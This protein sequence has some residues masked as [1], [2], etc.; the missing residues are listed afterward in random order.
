MHNISFS[1]IVLR[2][3]AFHTVLCQL[4]VLGKRFADAGLRDILIE[5]VVIAEGSAEAV[6]DGR[7]YNRAMRV[8]KVIIIYQLF[9]QKIC[10]NYSF[11]VH[12]WYYTLWLV[13]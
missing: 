4:R 9:I 11:T 7:H 5:S 12:L 2:L 3:G 6:L 13:L 8:H 10:Y 1:R